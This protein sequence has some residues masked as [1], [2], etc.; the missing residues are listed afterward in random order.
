[1]QICITQKS[2][3][4]RVIVRAYA[5][6]CTDLSR[7][8]RVPY[9]MSRR[10]CSALYSS[11]SRWRS[12]FLIFLPSAPRNFLMFCLV[13][14]AQFLNMPTMVECHTAS[15]YCH[16]RKPAKTQMFRTGLGWKAG[17]NENARRDRSPTWT[18]V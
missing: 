13:L 15:S 18:N 10:L 12:T 4:R 16:A 5:H 17:E 1:M 11:M 2:K 6:N 7:D 9:S 8:R 3:E 14:C